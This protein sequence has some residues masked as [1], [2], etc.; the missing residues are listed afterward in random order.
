MEEE[1]QN[2]TCARGIDEILSSMRRDVREW[3]GPE[4]WTPERAQEILRSYADAIQAAFFRVNNYR[5]HVATERDA[6]RE[7]CAKLGEE[8]AVEKRERQAAINDRAELVSSF[9]NRYQNIV[10]YSDG[11]REKLSEEMEKRSEGMEKLAEEMEKRIDLLDRLSAELGLP[12]RY[13]KQKG[14]D[15]V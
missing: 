2:E 3:F 5:E 13:E 10:D 15:H 1:T 12:A 11:L 4:D 8:L 14:A 6:L 9:N 7:D